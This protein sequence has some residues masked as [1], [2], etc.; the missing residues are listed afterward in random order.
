M[1]IEQAEQS[2][3]F[4]QKNHQSSF[5]IEVFPLQHLITNSSIYDTYE[6]D[7]KIMERLLACKVFAGLFHPLLADR[8]PRFPSTVE[9]PTPDLCGAAFSDRGGE[10]GWATAFFCVFSV[11]CGKFHG[12]IRVH[13]RHPWAN[14]FFCDLL[15]GLWAPVPSCIIRIDLC[16]PWANAFLLW[17][18]IFLIIPRKNKLFSCM[19]KN[20]SAARLCAFLGALA[21]ISTHVI[22]QAADNLPLKTGEGRKAKADFYQKSGLTVLDPVLHG[23]VR[24]QSADYVVIGTLVLAEDAKVDFPAGSR[25]FMEPSASIEVQGT[26]RAESVKI[27]NLPKDQLYVVIDESDTLW[28]AIIVEKTS[29]FHLIGSSLAGFKRGVIINSACQSAEIKDMRFENALQAPVVL[30]GV[31]VKASAAS[32]FTLEC[33]AGRK[34]AAKPGRNWRL[35]VAV[36]LG[37]VSVAGLV[38]VYSFD[39]RI[40]DSVD[41]GNRAATLSEAEKYDSQARQA[42]T[43]RNVFWGVTAAALVGA[44]VS[45]VVPFGSNR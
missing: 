8:R 41:K 23:I 38:A 28:D 11:V 25:I 39:K 35:P 10:G 1:N 16:D 20:L 3:S 19:L 36:S 12:I 33:D 4:R 40:W 27:R 31:P 42:Q 17:V 43:W 15:C 22:A 45:I 37:V 13:P 24:F 6:F 32:P 14:V 26:F 5:A 7:R 2:P 44:G 9:G 21:F 18:A 29:S 34:P 30:Q